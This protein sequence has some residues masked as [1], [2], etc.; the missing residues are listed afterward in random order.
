MHTRNSPTGQEKR[1]T[2]KQQQAALLLAQGKTIAATAEQVRVHEK[3]IDN[4][5]KLPRFMAEVHRIEDTIYNE[6][7]RLLMKTTTSAIATLIRNMGSDVSNYVQVSAASKLLDL[8][9]QVHRVSELEKEIA[10]LRQLLSN[11][12]AAA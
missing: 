12:D 3:S 5:K 7:L 9:L 1:L 11:D 10:E 6:Q 2:G 8:S 4:W